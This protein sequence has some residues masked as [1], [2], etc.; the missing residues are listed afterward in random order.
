MRCTH[1]GS[2]AA[3]PDDNDARRG[4]PDLDYLG[5]LGPRLQITLARLERLGQEMLVLRLQYETEQWRGR[6][7]Y[8]K[9]SV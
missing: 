5:E 9:C 4:L 1:P 7:G 8:E 3:E 6:D 2:F